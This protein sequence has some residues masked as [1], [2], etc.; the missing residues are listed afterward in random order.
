MS[1]IEWFKIGHQDNSRSNGRHGDMPHLLKFCHK[2]YTKWWLQ[3]Q[4]CAL[5]FP[6]PCCVRYGATWNCVIAIRECNIFYL[7]TNIY[8]TLVKVKALRFN[9]SGCQGTCPE[10]WLYDNT[11]CHQDV[12][13]N[14]TELHR[15]SLCQNQYILQN[16][17]MIIIH[18]LT[19]V[20][21]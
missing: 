10:G 7:T 11:G 4:I 13:H 6:L 3:E 12:V 20:L 21:S 1:R 9:I 19:L 2:Q 17:L 16:I 8:T 15:R 14:L 5:P 18:M